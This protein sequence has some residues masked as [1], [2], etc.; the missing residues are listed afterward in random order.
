VFDGVVLS[1][2]THEIE[3]R[4]CK[5]L[6][7][8]CRAPKYLRVVIEN[9]SIATTFPAV[10][11]LSATSKV[12]GNVVSWEWPGNYGET[13]PDSFGVWFSDSTP[14]DTSGTSDYTVAYKSTL[15][16]Y[17]HVYSGTLAYVAVRGLDGTDKSDNA[18]VALPTATAISGP[19]NQ[20]VEE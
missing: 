11:N 3:A 19:E 18:S 13:V 20:W 10:Q 14:P 16:N 8:N 7:D 1:D 6:W 4:P 12:F 9:G 2:G 15:K 5:Y 17:Q